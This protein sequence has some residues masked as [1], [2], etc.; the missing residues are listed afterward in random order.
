MSDDKVEAAMIDEFDRTAQPPGTPH[1]PARGDAWSGRAT[2][3]ARIWIILSGRVKLF[4]T[5]DGEDVIF[6]SES[7]GR[8][9]GLMSLSLQNPVFFSCRAVTEVTRAGPQPRAGARS[10][11]PEP[12]ALAAT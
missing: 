11:R 8:I 12:R 5:I 10:D 3:P 2:S 1:L 7:A 6:H 4:R 9:V